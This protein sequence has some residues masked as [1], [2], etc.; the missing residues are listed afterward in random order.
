M[1]LN[2]AFKRNHWLHLWLATLIFVDVL[3][4]LLQVAY[5]PV[6]PEF[7]GDRW[8]MVVMANFV[9]FFGTGIV[10]VDGDAPPAL[11]R[12]L[13]KVEA[14]LSKRPLIT[15]VLVLSLVFLWMFREGWFGHDK[16]MFTNDGGG[17]VYSRVAYDAA[18]PGAESWNDSWWLGQSQGTSPVN[19][20]YLLMCLFYHPKETYTAAFWGCVVFSVLRFMYKRLPDGRRQLFAYVCCAGI[21]LLIQAYIWLVAYPSTQN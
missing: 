11:S 5:P 20:S 3:L 16:V 18:W 9:T 1:Q 10:Y 6:F 15:L 8:L 7:A 14:V 2:A 13:S 17:Y 4:L 21:F 19:V 12:W